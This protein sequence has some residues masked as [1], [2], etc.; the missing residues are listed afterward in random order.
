MR[1]HS[2]TDLPAGTGSAKR[3]AALYILICYPQT[4]VSDL[5]VYLEFFLWTLLYMCTTSWLLDIV[6]YIT[7]ITRVISMSGFGQY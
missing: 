2:H 4:R 3:L 7:R 6:M 1:L 5:S